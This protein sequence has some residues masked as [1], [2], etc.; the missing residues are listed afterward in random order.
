MKKKPTRLPATQGP[1]IT[2]YKVPTEP[3]DLHMCLRKRMQEM[4]TDEWEDLSARERIAL[5]SAV[6]RIEVQFPKIRE[7]SYASNTNTGST[8]RQY[9]KAF[10]ANAARKR[11]HVPGPDT[12]LLNG[13]TGEDNDE[14]EY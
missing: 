5:L 10:A 13:R 7:G 12:E 4:M 8:V 11:K 2:A 1:T 14:L 9:E 3:D 6:A